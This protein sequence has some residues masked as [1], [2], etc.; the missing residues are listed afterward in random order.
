VSERPT[1]L[2]FRFAIAAG[3]LLALVV[4]VQTVAGYR[5]ISGNLV[6][7]EGQRGAERTVRA[8]RTAVRFSGVTDPAALDEV[9]DDI[10]AESPDRIAWLAIR[11]E[12]GQVLAASGTP[13]AAPSADD[14]GETLAGDDGTSRL[15]REGDRDVIVGLFACRCVP[16]PG[17]RAGR[18]GA[19]RETGPPT[20]GRGLDPSQGPAQLLAEVALFQDTVSAPFGRLRRTAVI[21]ASSAVALLVALV[22]IGT[23]FRDYVRGRELEMQLELA[24]RVQRDLLPPADHRPS[25]VEFAADCL[26]A[27]HVGGDFYDVL[28]L[29]PNHVSFVLGDVSGHGMSAALLM[30]LIHGAV[31]TGTWDG[32]PE[33]QELA[34]L[35]LNRLLLE[36]TSQEKFAT[37]FWCACDFNTHQL[38]YINAGHV[39]PLLVRRSA[40]HVPKIERLEQGGPVLGLLAS[41]TYQETRVSISDGDLLI[42]VSDGVLEA[43]NAA[44]EDFGEAGVLATLRDNVSRSAHDVRD[45]ILE[46]VHA[47]STGPRRDDQTLL[48]VNLAAHAQAVDETPVAKTA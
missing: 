45:A 16:P 28:D 19:A 8:L 31:S 17:S 27:A 12:G 38:W 21:N 15:E 22:V 25:G 44:G 36:K 35:R 10:R 9:L 14:V 18:R 6:R 29:G 2:W 43:T 41:A 13:G 47:F 33:A 4:L 5:F 32:P 48:V 42:I 40:G 23:R 3:V 34:M 11:S 7:Q 39:P 1:P 37:L 26:P 20:R 30:G 24:R 46:R